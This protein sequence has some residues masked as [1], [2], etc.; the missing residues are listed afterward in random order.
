EG[1]ILA[2]LNDEVRSRLAEDVGAEA[3][4]AA[5]EGLEIDDLADI[6]ADLPDEISDRVKESLSSAD[7]QQLESVLSFPED[8]A[9]GLMD[10]DTRSVR[11]DVTLEVVM[12]YL[13][14][15]GDL[16]D[17]TS[18]IFVVDRHDKYLGVLYFS[19]LVTHDEE[20]L[21]EDVMDDSVEPINANQTDVEVATLFQ[22]RDLVAAA[23]VDDDGRLLGQITVDD[24]VDVIKEQADH[25]ILSMAGL[26]EEDDMFAPVVT[27]TQ[28]RA[29][30][31]GVNLATAF[32]AS[33]VVALFR[34]ALEQ[35]VILAILMPIVASMGGIAGSQTLTLMIRGM[36]LG[37]V[38]DSNARTLFRKEIA[39]S[40]LNGLLWSVVVAAVTIT[41]FNSSWEVGAVIGFALIIS[42]LAAAL[43]GFAIP[44]I[45]HK[46][47]IDPALAG[48]VVLT[49]ITDVIGFGT[50]LG[51]GT[52]FLT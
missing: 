48:T 6:V 1:G 18:A 50:F 37:R 9:G 43:A 34:P 21:V 32:L 11:T 41:L 24:V 47:K 3:V 19:R 16:P 10:P 28:R 31:L 27:S 33:A 4:V 36:A 42:L 12:R 15:A 23:V 8:S 45:L 13:R 7:R 35:V 51:L 39:V 52:L 29:I 38:E 22:N 44:L 25:D 5:T 2:E 30:W 17:Q 46:M 49:T 40:L 20:S 14:R 26:D